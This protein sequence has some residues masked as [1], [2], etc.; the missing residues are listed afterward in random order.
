MNDLPQWG[1]FT[2]RETFFVIGT[3]FCFIIILDELYF[4]IEPVEYLMSD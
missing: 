4:Q 3:S 2:L 1:H